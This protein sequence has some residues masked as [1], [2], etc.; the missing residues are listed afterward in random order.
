MYIFFVFEVYVFESCFLDV[1]VFLKYIVSIICFYYIL[2]EVYFSNI[3]FWFFYIL[4]YVLYPGS[5]KGITTIIVLVLLLGGV[6]LLSISVQ[7]EYIGKILEETK[8]RPKYLIKEI[9][10]NKKKDTI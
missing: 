7:S 5:P 6:Q 4:Y 2:F 1:S 3:Y 8:N 10:N 9:I